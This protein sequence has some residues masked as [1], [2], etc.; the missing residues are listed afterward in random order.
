MKPLLLSIVLLG[1]GVSVMAGAPAPARNVR[2]VGVS[3]LEL[4]PRPGNP[5]NSEGAF[6]AGNDGRIIFVY[7]HFI[8]ESGSDHAKA[9]LAL[10]T[11]NDEGQTWSDDSFITTPREEEA[12]N[13]MSVS[14]LRLQNGDVGLLYLLRF[15]WHDM[16]MWMR[17]SADDGRTWS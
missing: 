7:S 16:R 2:G 4:P 3:V 13:V 9:R 15:S 17:R 12:M 10:R 5:R 11:S 8:G 1:V 6:L 14:L